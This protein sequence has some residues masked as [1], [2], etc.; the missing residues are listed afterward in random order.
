VRSARPRHN[1]RAVALLAACGLLLAAP[2]SGCATTQET[3]AMKQAESKRILEA[4]EKRQ[5]QRSKSHNHG[6]EKR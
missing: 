4:R 1:A 3:A 2:L 6:S 5:K